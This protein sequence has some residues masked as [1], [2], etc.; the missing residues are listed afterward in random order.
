M[1]KQQYAKRSDQNNASSF[2]FDNSYE[3][4]VGK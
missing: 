2:K 3:K 1:N 4:N